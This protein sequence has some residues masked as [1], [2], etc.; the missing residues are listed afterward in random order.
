METVL[1]LADSGISRV[2]EVLEMPRR[3][4]IKVNVLDGTL[5]VPAWLP[6][7]KSRKNTGELPLPKETMARRSIRKLRYMVD[8][9]EVQNKSVLLHQGDFELDIDSFNEYG[10][11]SVNKRRKEYRN[12]QGVLKQYT[13]VSFFLTFG[14]T[15]KDYTMDQLLC[16]YLQN[17][18]W[19]TRVYASEKRFELS[20]D[21]LRKHRSPSHLLYLE[22]NEWR[23]E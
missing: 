1:S 16:Y 8:N 12:P 11:R 6:P 10:I 13:T 22:D 3:L 19:K 20:F 14:K 17:R 18:V 9:R 2:A 7:A 23:F 5:E 15:T 4:R 21:F